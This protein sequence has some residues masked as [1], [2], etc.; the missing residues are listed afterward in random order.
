MHTHTCVI[1]AASGKGQVVGGAY[2]FW[3]VGRIQ[4]LPRLIPELNLSRH[5]SFHL[6]EKCPVFNAFGCWGVHANLL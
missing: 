5:E 4:F 1:G 2:V 6:A 3:G